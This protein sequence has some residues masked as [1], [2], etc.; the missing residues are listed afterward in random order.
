MVNSDR[1]KIKDSI[2]AL[3]DQLHD[4]LQKVAS[5]KDASDE[6]RM[7]II[8]ATFVALVAPWLPERASVVITSTGQIFP[9][10]TMF[11]G[12]GVGDEEIV[13]VSNFVTLQ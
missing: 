9:C 5:D 6:L 2:L 3:V 11:E 1:I 12:M 13:P 8:D 4:E 7:N 10:A